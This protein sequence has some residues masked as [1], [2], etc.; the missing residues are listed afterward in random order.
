MADE[1]SRSSNSPWPAASCTSWMWNYAPEEAQFEVRRAV[2][3]LTGGR[4]QV[5]DPD[6][7]DVADVLRFVK[8]ADAAQKAA[9]EVLQVTVAE[10]VARGASW[11]QIGE[12]LGIS[13]TGAHNRFGKGIGAE[14]LQ[15]LSEADEASQF[16][17]RCWA[18][19]DVE[20]MLGFD[21]EEWEAAPPR[22]AVQHIWRRVAHTHALLVEIFADNEQDQWV[23]LF[24]R[25]SEQL[26]GAVRVILTPKYPEVISEFAGKLP[27][28]SAWEDDRSPLQLFSQY[29]IRAVSAFMR[30][31]RFLDADATDPASKFRE[32][33]LAI[34]DLEQG[35]LIISQ[36]ECL[37]LI[38]AIEHS[39]Y[40]DGDTVYTGENVPDD[41][42]LAKSYEALWR[43]EIPPGLGID[44]SAGVEEGTSFS[45]ADINEILRGEPEG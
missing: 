9:A 24:H 23:T 41:M 18:H 30:L 40:A 22:V 25:A 10:A 6:A 15:L 35:A 5:A 3:N 2:A 14:T 13:K 39:I 33:L 36:P 26:R 31:N 28:R 38:V 1:R 45:L 27:P 42:N 16:C 7:P 12:Q 11:R 20:G 29:G 37:E 44:E 17:S 43:G 21:S 4:R 8:A 32:L 19:S 34:F